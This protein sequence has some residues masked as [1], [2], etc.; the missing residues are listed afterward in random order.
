MFW[1]D[2]PWDLIENKVHQIQ[3]RIVKYLKKAWMSK[4]VLF[5]LE[6]YDGKLSRTVLRG[7]CNLVTGF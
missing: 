3:T 7:V 2:I 1:D 4:D 5:R 6:P